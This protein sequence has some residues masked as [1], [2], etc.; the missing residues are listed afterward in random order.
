MKDDATSLAEAIREGRL[1]AVEA[2]HAALAAAER[3]S[4][5]G[6]IAYLDREMGLEEARTADALLAKQ[7]IVDSPF[8][9]VPSLAK[10]LGGPFAR[11][12]VAAGSDML[13]RHSA[14]PDSDLAAR[15][16]SAGLCFF[17][18]T[19]VPELG[20]SLSSEPAVGPQSRN[21]LDPSLSSGGSS[22]GAAAAVCAG[23][24]AIAHAT[25]AGGSIRVPAACC[26]LV[27]LKTTRG[28]VP[29]GPS[30][31]NHLGGIVS[32]LALCRSVRDLATIFHFASGEARG[33]YA[34]PHL[35]AA[36]PG[37]LRIGVL[38]NFGAAFT[39]DP[40][41][42]A[43]VEA[44]A[45]ALEADG[46]TL[47]PIAWSKFDHAVAASGTALGDIIAV[48]LA[49]YVDAAELDAGKAERLTLAF[50]RKGQTLTGQALWTSLDAGIH[51]S[52]ALWDLFDD[53]DC[54]LTPMLSSAPLPL[55]SFPFDHDD[56]DLQIQ[57]M[58]EFAPLAALANIT[59][60][61]AIT[62]PFGADASGLPLPVQIM[63]PMG[64]DELLLALG[65]RLEQEER[66]Q[67][68][69]PVAN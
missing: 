65:Q 10:D 38:S 30:F 48:N 57:R 18:L 19:T 50:I 42:A 3:Q 64:H 4:D 8:L 59:G 2:M 31:S 23:I 35:H 40:V 36:R 32:E 58:T 14:Q 24:V 17:G 53:V 39:L 54:I 47:V 43:A 12:P 41:R 69:F 25:D 62:L 68:R 13:D 29:G 67:H 21:P 28:A 27:G 66:W 26:G 44:A 37:A 20:L 45:T 9:G 55:G 63:A 22:G 60:F 5:L 7:S 34:D 6:A 56:V 16:R 61:P 52:R 11:L 1:S 15:V 33:P 51:A 49:N 46:H